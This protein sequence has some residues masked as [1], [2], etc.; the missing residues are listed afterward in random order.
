MITSS[1]ALRLLAWYDANRRPLS[2]REPP[3]DPYKIWI[4][5]IMLQQTT[6][7]TAE[8]YFLRF[9]ERFP[10]VQDLAAAPIDEVLWFWQG[11]GY[12][13]RAHH[14][15]K[16]AGIVASQALPTTHEGW[17]ALPGIGSYTASAILSI[18]FDQPEPAI[19]GNIHRILSRHQGSKH[20]LLQMR[21]LARQLLPDRRVGDYTQALMDLGAL[22]CRPQNPLC[23]VCPIAQDCYA[24]VHDCVSNFPEKKVRLRK[25]RY[26]HILVLERPQDGSLWLEKNTQKDLLKGLWGFPSS[27]W[28]LTPAPCPWNNGSKIG[29]LKHIFTHFTLFV[30]VWKASE[31]INL[32][33]GD[34]ALNLHDYPLSS[35]MRKVAIQAG[36]T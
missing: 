36:I 27:S 21:P 22:V 19:D 20:T 34:W 17:L 2:W 10:R 13:R 15:H 8:P 7:K 5:E 30:D 16:A 25:A 11:L 28:E 4:S 35:L 14:L 12:Y 6:V 18:A 32:S 3:M 1:F 9:M 24:R 29:S 31:A 23:D 26:A 33:Q